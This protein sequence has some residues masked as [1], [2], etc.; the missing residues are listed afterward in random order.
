MRHMRILHVITSLDLG[1]AE[2]QLLSLVQQ[3]VTSGDSV[4][5]IYL[6]GQGALRGD[7][8]RIGVD[9]IKFNR[10]TLSK[11][12]QVLMSMRDSEVI[13]GHL[14][15]AELV[16]AISSF[17]INKVILVSKHN[18]ER[19]YPGGN[20]KLSQLMA[21]F[22]ESRTLATICI[23]EEVLQH[24][25]RTSEIKSEQKY[26]VIHYGISAEPHN[27]IRGIRSINDT[28]QIKLVSISRLVE[29]KNLK[30]LVKAVS[31]LPENFVLDIWGIGP[32]RTRLMEQIAELKLLNRIRLKGLTTTPDEVFQNGD[33]FVLPSL[34]EGFGLVLL[35]AMYYKTP[36]VASNIAVVREIL[37]EDYKYLCNP[38][39]AE[40]FAST[41]EALAK[42]DKIELLKKYS[43]TLRKFDI[44][45]SENRIKRLYRYLAESKNS[46]ENNS[47]S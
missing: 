28:S 34:Y 6:K 33:I 13:H 26:H 35:E 32:M 25:H 21:R 17:F 14:P 41:L 29:Q 16:V 9:L 47:V 2:R 37:G 39:S 44:K 22:V 36:I 42:G 12:R 3:Q 45:I 30:V 15:R 46:G 27:S 38:D 31:L 4:T 20:K 18:A 10:L 8:L 19:F 23:S 5:V 1:G 11:V 40:E 43:A 7:F 24:L